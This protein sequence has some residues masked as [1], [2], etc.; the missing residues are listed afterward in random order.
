MRAKL[1]GAFVDLSMI[2]DN[3]EQLQG[4]LAILGLLHLVI[5]LVVLL[6]KPI[7]CKG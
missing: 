5:S 1:M 2:L 7:P 6:R 4:C 3:Y